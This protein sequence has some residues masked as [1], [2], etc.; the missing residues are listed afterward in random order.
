MPL[1]YEC[2]SVSAGNTNVLYSYAA[3]LPEYCNIVSRK[4]GG[5]TGSP[6]FRPPLA[7]IAGSTKASSRPGDAIKRMAPSRPR[8][9][10]ER[11]LTAEKKARS[12]SRG[13]S[14]PPTLI[15]SATTPAVSGLKRETSECLL[16]SV[17]P[18]DSKPPMNVFRGGVLKSKRFSQ[19]E[20]DMSFTANTN[21]AKL[22]RKAKVEEEL[23][24]AIAA[25]KRPNRGLA[26][27]EFVETSE[28][29]A[30]GGVPC[31]KG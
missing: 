16:L 24:E 2:I 7:K 11:V 31:S 15:R 8:Q 28:R 29:R 30:L 4:L 25:L 20:I 22:Q 13:P 5:P 17:P 9:T 14:M 26:I 18:V 12:V 1:L 3:R 19:R 27:K 10:L 21:N 6:S 23:K